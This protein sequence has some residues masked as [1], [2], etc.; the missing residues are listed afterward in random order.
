SHWHVDHIVDNAAYAD[1]VIVGHNH[2]RD[3]MLA[4][5]AEF[6]RGYGD[7]DPFTVVPPNLTFTGRLDLW[8]DD[9][10]IELHEVAIH[11]AGHLGVYL[12][13]HKILIA[14]DLLEDPLWFFDFDFASAETQRAELDR[15]ASWDIDCILPCHGS[16]DTLRQGGYS[17]RLIDANRRYLDAMLALADG[18]DVMAVSAT[19]ILKPE[20][21]AGVLTWWPPYD[22]VHALNQQAVVKMQGRS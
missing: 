16:V 2:T 8:L 19:E 10:A 6:E 7:Y 13:E 18:G 17:K 14:N 20:L 15:L 5:R 3:V 12:P 9:L 21:D 22:E 4:K 11:E 1:G